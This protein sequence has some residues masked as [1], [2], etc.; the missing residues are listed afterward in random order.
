MN[1]PRKQQTKITIHFDIQKVN[2]CDALRDV[3]SASY[4]ELEAKNFAVK[5]DIPDAPVFCLCDE[6]A[7][8]R[9]LQNLFKN[10]HIHGKKVLRVQLDGTTI[11]IANRTDG[12]HELDTERIFERFYTADASRTSKNTGLGL[13]IAKEL[14]ARTGGQIAAKVEEDMLVIRVEFRAFHSCT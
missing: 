2:V 13:A 14:V 8:R 12:L 11:E 7:L 9:V 5:A 1:P 3:L 6:N 4:S 10:V